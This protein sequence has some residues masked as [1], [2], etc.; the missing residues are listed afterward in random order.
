MYNVVDRVFDET[1]QYVKGLNLQRHFR[2]LLE[3]YIAYYNRGIYVHFNF[4]SSTTKDCF[5]YYINRYSLKQ[6]LK[7]T[8][9]SEDARDT[10]MQIYSAREKNE[11]K[12][13]ILKND[14]KQWEREY[15]HLKER[16]DHYG[17]TQINDSQYVNAQKAI[18]SIYEDHMEVCKREIGRTEL[19]AKLCSVMKERYKR[20]SEEIQ[21][22]E[23]SILTTVLDLYMK[24]LS[25]KIGSMFPGLRVDVRYSR[26]KI[27]ELYQEKKSYANNSITFYPDPNNELSMF[28]RELLGFMGLAKKMFVIHIYK[29][30]LVYSLDS[31]P[32]RD[33]F[34][35][36]IEQK[37]KEYGGPVDQSL[38][39]PIN[40][41][42][43]M[44]EG[45][46]LLLTSLRRVKNN[47]GETSDAV[48]DIVK[49]IRELYS[50]D[51]I[52][53]YNLL[54][55]KL[56]MK[57]EEQ[58]QRQPKT[59][60]NKEAIQQMI[61]EFPNYRFSAGEKND[62]G[63]KHLF[64]QYGGTEEDFIIYFIDEI[65]NEQYTLKLKE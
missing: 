45:F 8:I 13:N 65:S 1:V 48:E 52:T 20:L 64:K 5:G 11:K 63:M 4:G 53:R 27:L 9:N 37:G 40:Q 54:Q 23:F 21:N 58:E 61:V 62:E 17:S 32:H 10:R 18:L 14:Y 29:G 47:F 41:F 36:S 55:K 56:A 22:A 35:L 46:Y 31:S 16:L 34:T 50:E 15:L 2:N 24:R 28:E 33:F 26:K 19:I 30:N 25:K 43:E 42:L 57:M 39:E 51:V 12:R 7:D 59:I 44:H 49:S 6:S 60:G 38:L 3:R